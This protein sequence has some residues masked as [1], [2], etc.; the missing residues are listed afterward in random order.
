MPGRLA[1]VGAMIRGMS[2]AYTSK[3]QKDHEEKVR[4][5]QLI[6][7]LVEGGIQSGLVK[8]PNAA[9]SFMLDEFGVK[10]KAKGKHGEGTNPIGTIVSAIHQ[11]EEAAG[12]GSG[13]ESEAAA[14]GGAGASPA[15]Q[16]TPVL[17]DFAQHQARPNVGGP[18][19]ATSTGFPQFYTG[20]EMAAKAQANRVTTLTGDIDAKVA[21]AKRLRAQFPNLTVEESLDAVGLRI[22]QAR[23][24]APKVTGKPIPS[25]SL[26][27]DAKTVEGQKLEAKPGQT[28][29][30]VLVPTESG[31][32]EIR[33]SVGPAAKP[34]FTTKDLDAQLRTRTEAILASKGLNPSTV[35]PAVLQTVMQEAGR[36]LVFEAGQRS[37]AEAALIKGR[38]DNIARNGG[39]QG[40]SAPGTTGLK[41]EDLPIV[42]LDAQGR[43]DPETQQAY[44][45]SFKADPN[46]QRI[47][48]GLVDYS[49]NPSSISTRPINGV[50]RIALLGYAK[51]LDPT[52]DEKEYTSRQK[53]SS[54]WASGKTRDSMVATNTVVRHLQEM[55]TAIDDLAPFTANTFAKARNPAA[56][57]MNAQTNP[58]MRKAIRAFET[59]RDAVADELTRVYR[60]T[61]GSV[62]DIEGWKKNA[63]L[64]AATDEKK[65]FIN[66]AAKLMFGRIDSAVD[67]YKATMR[68]APPPGQGLTSGSIDTLKKLG[69]DVGALNSALA[70]P[71]PEGIR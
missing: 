21:A 61:G 42:Q 34:T 33:Y 24:F 65:T 29:Q 55:M 66:E 60:G 22:P 26:P 51:G 2:S 70:L 35:D 52:Y 18:A 9:I 59:A 10:D 13:T 19:G 16:N 4:R 69:V 11:G 17:G 20:D 25:E 40:L 45:D 27:D 54:D 14:P 63:D 5:Q 48:K 53:L 37:S 49:I 64:Y 67:N 15:P 41:G 58:K 44:L 46:M 43:P 56:Y 62:H 38:L 3:Q 8:D 32:S 7:S 6:A 1:A 23:T 28:Y 36:A 30:P 71:D 57:T 50:N 68:K 39:S 31:V 47:L 12:T